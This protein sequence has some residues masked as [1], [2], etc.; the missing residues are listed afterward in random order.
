MSHA[1]QSPLFSPLRLGALDLANR[2]IMAPL[3]RNRAIAGQVP[4]PLAAEYYAQRASAGL[5]VAEA[6]QINPLGQGYLDTPGI[7]TPAQIEGWRAVTQ[8]VHQ[9]GGKIVLQLWH[10]GR[11]S[12]TSVLP[13][14][15]VPVA[16][17]AIRAEGKTFTA[18]GFQDLS[19]PRELAL[20]EIPALIE[21]YRLA[22]RNAIDA[23]FD[24]V[25]V[26]AANGYLLDQFLRDGSNRRTDAYGGDI[27]NRTRL[28]VEVVQAVVDEIGADRTGVRLSP[29]TPVYDMHDSNPQA[30][31][32][33]AVERLN[34]IGGLAFVHVIEGSTGGPRDNIAFDYAA[35]RAKFDGG[36]IANNGYDRGMA[37]QAIHRGYADAIAFGRPF[38]ANPDLVRRL[39]DH[40]PLAELDQNTLYGGGAAGYTDYPALPD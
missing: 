5:I 30:L 36:W 16:P 34:L 9:R 28:L 23:G 39:H 21:D 31:F 8:A 26:H 17:S 24:G 4:S 12:H 7:Y 27:E 32:E 38:I 20:E 35:L 11:V 25:E 3:T 18:D 2:I 6:T 29:V 15:E 1:S 33:R 13:P 22:A 19:A 10:V 40:A 37:E 14:G